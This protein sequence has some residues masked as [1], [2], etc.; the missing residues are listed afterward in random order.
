MWWQE[1]QEAKVMNL[2]T[3]CVRDPASKKK[4]KKPT[5]EEQKL[6]EMLMTFKG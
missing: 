6:G 2:W 4:K 1:D 5:T 3:T